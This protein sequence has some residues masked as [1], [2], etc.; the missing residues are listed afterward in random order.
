MRKPWSISTTVRN[1]ERLK[2]FLAVLKN[3]EGEEFDNKTQIRYQILLIK[4]KLYK[5]TKIP[6]KYKNIFEDMRSEIPLDVAQ[7]VFDYQKYEDPPMRGRQSV[8]PLNKLG[9]SIAREKAGV[10]RITELGNMFLEPDSDLSYI[11]FKSLLKMQFENPWSEDFKKENGF[12]VRP[13]IAAMHLMKK[14][15]GLS[16]E[17][18]AYFMPTLIHYK[19][20]R[21]Y[22]DFIYECRDL[23]SQ[24]KKESFIKKFLLKFYGTKNLTEV[25]KNNLSDYG[26]NAMRYFRLTKYFRVEKEPLGRWKI[27]LETSRNEE[28]EQLLSIY[29]GSAQEFKEV[30]EY[31]SYLSDIN[32]PE[33]PWESDLQKLKSITIS[34]REMIAKEFN[35][36]ELNIQ[37]E[38]K[39]EF[40]NLIKTDIDKMNLVDLN[41]FIRNARNFRL[42]VIQIKESKILRKNIK[43]LKELLSVLKDH[44]KIRNLEPVEFEHII[45][46]TLKILNDEIGIKQ[47]CIFDDSGNPIV[48]APRNRADIEGYYLSF[49]SILEVTLDVTRTQAYRESIPIMRHLRDF[50]IKNPDRPSYCVFVAPRIHDD[51]VNYLWY[52]NKYGFEG[53]RQKIIALSLSQYINI[54]EHFIETVDKY[55]KFG[56][57]DLKK[58]YDDIISDLENKDS[59]RN[60]YGSVDE[61]IV[62]WR[63]KVS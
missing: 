7:E 50:E 35:D 45:A 23:K 14:T 42:K 18:F 46:Q 59:S 10:I 60:W 28:I 56:H 20:I 5:P 31:M 21:K 54:L 29:D 9:F 3:L 41:K 12:N 43:F 47:N 16:R 44:K 17:E 62:N 25:Q 24:S 33:L 4:E 30:E 57:Q 1:P 34:L 13:L 15:K 38:N 52:S 51:T 55:G 19:D 27:Q 36:L 22:A 39:A 48:F 49:N 11:F 53:K 8:N 63:T 26:D 37:K 58:L 2:E 40:D 32:K 61:I 6:N